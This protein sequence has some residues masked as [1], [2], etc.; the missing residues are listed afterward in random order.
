[1]TR[2]VNCLALLVC[3]ASMSR[4]QTK[5]SIV[6]TRHCYQL[7][8]QTP[9]H[10]ATSASFPHHVTIFPGRDSGEVVPESTFVDSVGF[11]RRSSLLAY[12]KPVSDSLELVFSNGFS[13]AVL[14][15][16]RTLQDSLSGGGVYFSDFYTGEPP[17][18]RI[19]AVRVACSQ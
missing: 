2:M 17:R 8:Y 5:D 1:M 13:S 16:P 7:S 15:L 12:W 11:G 3:L 10:G 14:R 19:H 9:Q 4:A 18:M 6:R